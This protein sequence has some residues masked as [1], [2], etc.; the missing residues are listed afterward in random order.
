MELLPEFSA[1]AFEAGIVDFFTAGR[2]KKLPIKLTP[3]R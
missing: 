1:E 2:K 3:R